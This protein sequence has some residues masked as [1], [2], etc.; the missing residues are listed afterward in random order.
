MPLIL[1]CVFWKYNEKRRF[2]AVDSVNNCLVVMT[3]IFACHP[4]TVAVKVCIF[5]I[6]ELSKSLECRLGMTQRRNKH[7]WC[8]FGLRCLISF[9]TWMSKNNGQSII[10]SNP[11][12]CIFGEM[13]IQSQSCSFFQ[14][15]FLWN[16]N[17]TKKIWTFR[18]WIQAYNKTNITKTS[19]ILWQ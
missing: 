18:S 9:Q 3:L 7:D 1:S 2:R 8:R 4:H 6:Y 13:L 19:L 12:F 11:N 17:E 14:T 10:K 16:S 5:F 15:I